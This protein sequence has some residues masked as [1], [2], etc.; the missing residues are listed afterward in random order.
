MERLRN[1]E[2]GKSWKEGHLRNRNCGNNLIKS[3]TIN[4]LKIYSA[5][6]IK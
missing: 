3:K 1:V 6:L 5:F 4:L 2:R